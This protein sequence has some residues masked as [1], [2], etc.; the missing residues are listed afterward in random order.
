MK[1]LRIITDENAVEHVFEVDVN[2]NDVIAQ[3]QNI[4][5]GWEDHMFHNC[6]EC[7]YVEMTREKYAQYIAHH[8]R[9]HRDYIEHV[10]H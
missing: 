1:M 9:E 6:E 3:T 8:A 5:R 10:F 7:V 4:V 2:I